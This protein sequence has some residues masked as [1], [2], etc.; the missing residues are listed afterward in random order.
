MQA[1]SGGV[2][3]GRVE[4]SSGADETP[5]LGLSVVVP[6]FNEEA[7]LAE[8]ERRLSAVCDQVVEDRYEIILVNDGSSDQTGKLIREMAGRNPRIIGLDLARN[9]G[10]QIALTAGLSFARGRRTLI[11]DADL[12]DPPELLSAMMRLMDEGPE[13]GTIRTS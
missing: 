10:H 6:C 1:D 11:L 8:L 3:A 2:A 7:V 5:L 4:N 12:Q 13:P 9:Y